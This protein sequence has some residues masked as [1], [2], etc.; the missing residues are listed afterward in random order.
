MIFPCRGLRQ[1]K[2]SKEMEHVGTLGRSD[3]AEVRQ[4]HTLVFFE[5]SVW[6]LQ[7]LRGVLLPISLSPELLVTLVTSV[8]PAP[9]ISACDHYYSFLRALR[10]SS[11]T[12]TLFLL[13][14]SYRISCSIPVITYMRI[15]NHYHFSWSNPSS[16]ALLAPPSAFIL[17]FISYFFSH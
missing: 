11:F 5:V 1:S 10:S 8:Q 4:R 3:W 7:L 15:V 16:V 2:D 13:L 6:L 9:I 14:E 17:P 12:N